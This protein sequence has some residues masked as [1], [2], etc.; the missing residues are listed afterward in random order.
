MT[1]PKIGIQLIVFGEK[2]KTDIAG[3]LREVAQAGYEGIEADN[4]FQN[5]G[6]DAVRKLI[7]ETGLSVIGLHRGY[8]D[9]VQEETIEKDIDYL[10]AVGGTYLICSGVSDNNSLD[11][12]E[13]SAAFFN[14]TGKRCRDAGLVFM[15]H[16]HNWEFQSFNGTKAIH[17][18]VELCDPALVKLCIDVY[19]VHIG[20]EDPSTF[21]ARYKDRAGYY[22]FKDGSPGKF[23]ELG[24]GEVD[25]MSAKQAALAA[26]ADWIIC[27]QD[28]T[29]KSTLQSITE[30]REYLRSI[31][32]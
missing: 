22:H 31:G 12:Y 24:Q 19:W 25:L 13:N 21:I 5:H 7:D 32:L 9:L 29:E 14:E 8:D 23:I 15:Y 4:L 17:R 2:Q 6:E 16:N 30:S 27:E 26:G 1:Q 11:G 10:K 28:T 20:G 3:V 18:L